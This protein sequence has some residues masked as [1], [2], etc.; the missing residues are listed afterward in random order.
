MAIRRCDCRGQQPH[1]WPA[2]NRLEWAPGAC[3]LDEQATHVLIAKWRAGDEQALKELLPLIYEQLHRVARQHL[4]HQRVDHTLQ[5]TALIHEAHLRL[6]GGADISVRDRN[7]FVALASRM[8][9]EVL[10]DHARGRLR[11]KRQ[12]GVRVTLS[13]AAGVADEIDVLGGLSIQET[14][15]ALHISES[16]VK[17][18]WTMA[19]TWLSRELQNSDLQ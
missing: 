19:R 10:V 8:V 5:T 7:H 4:R 17:R 9:R 18:D 1:C 11:A 3:D 14:A 15:D 13:E 6:A 16:T 12:G 2:D